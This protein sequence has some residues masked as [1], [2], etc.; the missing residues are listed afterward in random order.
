MGKITCCGKTQCRKFFD[1]RRKYGSRFWEELEKAHPYCECER[2][3]VSGYSPGP[4]DDDETL[5]SVVTSENY[6]TEDGRIEF[7]FF[8][9]R[10]SKGMS[11]DRKKYTSRHCYDLRAE[12]L[13]GASPR[14]EN[15]GSIELEVKA[16]RKINYKEIRAIAVYDTA[17]RE[18]KSHSEIVCAEVPPKGTDNRTKLRAELRKEILKAVLNDRRVLSS[19]DLFDH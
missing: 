3:S 7:T 19:S 4:V 1:D 17:L 16:I 11:V 5:I 9:Q 2:V 6:L 15:C 8:D 13:I 18:N 14:K 10:I 12:K